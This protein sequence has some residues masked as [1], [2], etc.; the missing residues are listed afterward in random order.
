MLTREC[1][2]QTFEQVAGQE[3]NKKILKS[4]IN[5]PGKAPKCLIFQG[6]FGTGK[7]TMSRIF[8]MALNCESHGHKPCLKCA[9]CMSMVDLGS[10]PFY[11][12]YDS[13]VVGS[14]S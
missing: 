4:I 13:A 9:T 11:S 6:E 14:I 1:R 10:T 2:P 3:L 5:S 8:A 7:T 12:E